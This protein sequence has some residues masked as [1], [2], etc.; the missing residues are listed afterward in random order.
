MLRRVRGRSPPTSATR[1][2]RH[3]AR[4]ERDRAGSCR[5]RGGQPRRTGGG[6]CASRCGSP[7]AWPAL[8]T[9]RAYRLFVEVGPRPTLLGMA[10]QSVAEQR[11]RCGCPRCAR[12]AT[13]GPQL[14]DSLAALYAARRRRSTGPASTAATLAARSRCRPIR[15]SASGTGSRRPRAPRACGGPRRADAGLLR[16]GVAAAPRVEAAA[17]LAEPGTWI[18]FADA[19][20]VGAALARRLEGARPANGRRDARRALR[21]RSGGNDPP[22][23]RSPGGL[24]PAVAGDRLRRCPPARRRPPVE[25]RRSDGRYPERLRPRPGHRPRAARRLS[26]W[27]AS[28]AQ[29]RGGAAAALPRDARSASRP[30]EAIRW[31]SARPRCGVSR[32]RSPSSTPSSGAPRWTWIQRGRTRASRSGSRSPLHRK[33]SRSPSVTAAVSCRAWCRPP[34][35][36]RAT[37]FGLRARCDLPD[38][39]RPGRPRPAP[40]AV[41]GGARSAA[42]RADGP[43][44][45]D[46][47]SGAALAV[48]DGAGRRRARG[49]GRRRA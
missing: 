20:D 32:E 45:P 26:T 36:G 40:G 34:S 5:R 10:A 41:D 47:G 6:T 38:H 44:R 3:P 11:Q 17:E 46:R 24:Q 12:R 7:T 31:R 19:G 42:P 25:P 16:D 48:L 28:C 15:S 18:V 39:R 43:P 29:R 23:S 35:R 22:R 9:R 14:L 4:L 2:P 27:W 1:A 30:A 33:A 49:P 8:W 37:A 13:T 21:S